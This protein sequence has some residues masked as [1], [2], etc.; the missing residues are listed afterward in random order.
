[1]NAPFPRLVLGP[2]RQAEIDLPGRAGEAEPRRA[3]PTPEEVLRSF[4]LTL[5]ALLGVAV[6][7]DLV[8]LALQTT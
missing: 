6:I 1:M 5:I 3:Y 8:V 7:G 4:A 2:T